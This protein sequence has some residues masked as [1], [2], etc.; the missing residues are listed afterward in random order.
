MTGRTS[1]S[2]FFTSRLVAIWICQKRLNQSLPCAGFLGCSSLPMANFFAIAYVI[3]LVAA[4]SSPPSP[5]SPP[6]LQACPPALAP[7]ALAPPAQAPPGRQHAIPSN[8]KLQKPGLL[9]AA[10]FI[11][12]SPQRRQFLPLGRQLHS[13][14]RTLQRGTKIFGNL[15]LPRPAP[16][17]RASGSASS[18]E[19]PAPLTGHT[20][21]SLNFSLSCEKTSNPRPSRNLPLRKL[22]RSPAPGSQALPLQEPMTNHREKSLSLSLSLS[23]F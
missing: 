14:A 22:A 23:G 7:A 20:D 16:H 15:L 9:D 21:A 1:Q 18:A 19:T 11:Q 12:L 10:N 5:R 17:L 2:R 6:T 8:A 4:K 13:T 3:P